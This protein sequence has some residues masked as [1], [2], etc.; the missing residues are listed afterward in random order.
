[1]QNREKRLQA[2]GIIYVRHEKRVNIH[3]LVARICAWANVF[4]RVNA[5][6][7]RYF[8]KCGRGSDNKGERLHEATK[9]KLT[10]N[11]AKYRQLPIH[12]L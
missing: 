11:S 10:W 1:M 9:R 3:V 5:G 8:Q 6:R 4:E 2:D 7:G 12:K